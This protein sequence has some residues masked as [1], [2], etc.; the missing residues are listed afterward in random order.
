MTPPVHDTS[1]D[2]SHEGAEHHGSNFR[3]YWIVALVL[4]VATI[5]EVLLSEY[6]HARNITGG[7]LAGSM[8][9]IALVKAALVVLYYMHLK[10]ERRILWI[11]WG[12]PFFLVSLLMLA[13][14]AQP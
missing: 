9:G 10:Y 13:L 14:F 12:I 6:L 2:R 5:I 11:I 3:L 4:G 7:I 1:G 8:M